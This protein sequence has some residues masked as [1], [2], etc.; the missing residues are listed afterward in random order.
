M[1]AKN[2]HTRVSVNTASELQALTRA[3]YDSYPFDFL[4]PNDEKVIAQMQPAPFRRFIESYCKMG[5]RIA[6]IGC[7]PGRGTIYLQRKSSSIVAVDLSNH[8]IQLARQRAPDATFVQATNLQ[9]PFDNDTFDILVSDGVIHHTPNAHASFIENT[10]ILKPGGAMYLGVYNRKR[11][12][13]YIYTYI[14][15][16]VRRLQQCL[17]GRIIIYSTLIP[18]Y[19]FVHLIKSRGR[20]SLRG[21]INFFYDYIITPRA[22]FHTREEIIGWGTAQGLDLASYDA[23]LGNVH[24]FFFSKSKVNG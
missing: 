17:L 21:A 14:G 18:I 1:A 5:S 6:E 7:G 4:T 22:S 13:Y 23:H 15:P 9:L 24:V 19:Y 3:H 8:S 16:V 20:R 10:R 12:Y 2:N 11:Y